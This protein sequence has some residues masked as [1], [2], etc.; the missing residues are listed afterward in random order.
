[1]SRVPS[2]AFAIFEASFFPV[3]L[4][5]ITFFTT[6][7]T[8]DSEMPLYLYSQIFIEVFFPKLFRVAG[9]KLTAMKIQRVREHAKSVHFVTGTQVK[10]VLPQENIGSH[11]LHTVRSLCGRMRWRCI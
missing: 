8:D 10:S 11:N 9:E 2:S 7:F 3:T 4:S 1:M 5:L 6:L